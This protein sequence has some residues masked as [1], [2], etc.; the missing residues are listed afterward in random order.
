V[1]LAKD[2]RQLLDFDIR[3]RAGGR[4]MAAQH[5]VE[6]GAP[7]VAL[8]PSHQ[9][10]E[11]MPARPRTLPFIDAASTAAKKSTASNRKFA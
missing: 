3:L 11:R 8:H 10:I 9:A 4:K 2:G 5:R 1:I 7:F 6:S